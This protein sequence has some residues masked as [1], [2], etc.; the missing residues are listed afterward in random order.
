MS[1]H[2]SKYQINLWSSLKLVYLD[3]NSYY[4]NDNVIDADDGYEGAVVL[5]PKE[6]IYLNEPIV[7]FDYGSLYP[8]SMISRNLSHDCFLMDEK[9]RIDDPNIEY[10]NIYYDIYEGKG[11]KK[12]KVGQKECTFIQYKDG[13]KGIIADILD[14]LLVERKNTRK[15][16]AL[17]SCGVER[18]RRQGTTEPSEKDIWI[19]CVR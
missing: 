8:S 5:E 12:K 10:K 6:G 19:V 9:Y 16:R 3:T 2:V 15:N 1:K 13:K 7:V 11:D 18:T 14:M 17:W 4:F